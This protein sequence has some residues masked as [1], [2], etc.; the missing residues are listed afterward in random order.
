MK[1][2]FPAHW[3]STR[4]PSRAVWS[5]GFRS[6][7][8][9]RYA[10]RSAPSSSSQN[11]ANQ[12]PIKASGACSTIAEMRCVGV[13]EQ[14]AVH[15]AVVVTD[16]GDARGVDGPLGDQPVE[17]GPHGGHLVLDQGDVAGRAV[18]VRDPREVA[19]RQHRDD[20]LPGQRDGLGEVL[21][22][23]AVDLAEPVQPQH[24]GLGVL[25]GLPRGP[26]EPGLDR[27]LPRHRDRD[28]VHDHLRPASRRGPACRPSRLR[29]P[30]ALPP[31]PS[32]PPPPSSVVPWAPPS[33]QLYKCFHY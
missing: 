6:S 16:Q 15:G 1:M 26:D 25:L 14:R 3:N 31:S 24:P 22:A 30:P 32:L 10:S 12:L 29:P 13:G 11:W 18:G 23:V 8:R 28:V 33:R 2:S 27:V 7:N 19:L 5:T 17:G 9:A 20:A 4:S 21:V